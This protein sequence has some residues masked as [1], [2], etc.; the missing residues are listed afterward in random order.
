MTPEYRLLVYLS[1]LFSIEFNNIDY[2]CKVDC[3]CTYFGAELIFKG[4][5]E[6]F[7]R[8]LRVSL[9]YTVFKLEVEF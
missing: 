9:D 2:F 7:P 4:F 8:V 6:I 1:R 5:F 3:P